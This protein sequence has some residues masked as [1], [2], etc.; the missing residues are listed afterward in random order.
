MAGITRPTRTRQ[1]VRSF[2]S[3]HQLTSSSYDARNMKA[4]PSY[5]YVDSGYPDILPAF[6]HT[7]SQSRMV[8]IEPLRTTTQTKIWLDEYYRN[9]DDAE[10]GSIRSSS[11]GDSMEKVDLSCGRKEE[12]DEE[13]RAMPFLIRPLPA[14][15]G[16]D[17]DGKTANN[18]VLRWL[19]T[20]DQATEWLSLFYGELQKAAVNQS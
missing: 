4:G 13:V 19:R 14:N 15:S 9:N 3:G 5:K 6:R 20:E 2:S 1:K 8:L 17:E 16:L 18:G 7:R 10:K 11:S 12:E